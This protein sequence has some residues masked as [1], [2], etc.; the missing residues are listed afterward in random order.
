MLV[1]LSK[2]QD[3]EAGDGTTSVVVMCGALLDQ[4][5]QLLKKGIHP[6]IVTEAFLTAALKAE[7]ILN[8]MAIP[9]DLTNRNKLIKAAQV[10]SILSAL[11]SLSLFP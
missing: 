10:R 11:Q 2:A 3:V 8:S 4:A 5:S 9:V 7:E 1:E 6:T